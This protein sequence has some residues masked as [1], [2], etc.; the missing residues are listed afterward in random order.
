M[1][2]KEK[3]FD[4]V[5]LLQPDGLYQECGEIWL[6]HTAF[7]AQPLAA[8]RLEAESREKLSRKTK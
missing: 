6:Q 5:L 1:K 7:R 2:I 8:G 3:I 4:S